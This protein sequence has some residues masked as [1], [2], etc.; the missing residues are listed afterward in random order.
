MT[1]LMR[2]RL[3]VP[4]L[5]ITTEWIDFDEPGDRQA[6]DMNVANGCSILNMREATL[7][8]RIQRIFEKSKER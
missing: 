2:I 1:R 6:L 5:G 3:G 7:E 4:K 8:E